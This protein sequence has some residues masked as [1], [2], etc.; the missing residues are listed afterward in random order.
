MRVTSDFFVS[1][2]VRRIFNG[3]GFAAV[4]KRGAPEAGAVFV[5]VDRLDGT[6]DFYGPAPQS[7]FSDLPD[8]RLFERVLLQADREML[9]DRLQKEGR[10]DPDY[11]LV[12]IEARDGQVELPLATDEPA[13][14][15]TMD[16]GKGVFRF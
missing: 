4:S 1:A 7:M 10:M 11:W 9:A 3:G 5:S 12:E 13:A 16:P 8:G 15:P 14:D 6:Y 2:L